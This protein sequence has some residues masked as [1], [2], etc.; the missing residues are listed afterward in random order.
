[1]D[2]EGYN[3]LDKTILYC[4]MKTGIWT[5]TTRVCY[6]WARLGQQEEQCLC[7]MEL[8]SSD[9]GKQGVHVQKAHCWRRVLT[10][11]WCIHVRLGTGMSAEYLGSLH[12]CWYLGALQTTVLES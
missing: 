9:W 4:I 1:M 6:G 10:Q 5:L 12:A 3:R 8:D 11:A 2:L 7:E